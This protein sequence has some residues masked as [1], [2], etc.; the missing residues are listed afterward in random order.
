MIRGN[1]FELRVQGGQQLPALARRLR[2]LGGAPMRKRFTGTLRNSLKPVVPAV[3]KSA[4][5]IPVHGVKH[6]GLRKRL[7]AATAYSVRATG[8]GAGAIVI[9]SAKRMPAGEKALPYYMEGQQPWR[10]RVYGRDVWVTQEPHPFFYRIVDQQLPRIQ[11]DLERMLDE[12]A[13][14]LEL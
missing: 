4:L 13:R 12:I 5:A 2:E 7:A 14:D 9:V 6:S 8:R 10:H 1:V 3:R 11:K